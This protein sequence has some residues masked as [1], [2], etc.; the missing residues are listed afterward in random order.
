MGFDTSIED[1]RTEKHQLV[2]LKPRY[3]ATGWSNVSGSVYRVAVTRG[4]ISGVW[5]EYDSRVGFSPV[6]SLASLTANNEYFFDPATS[7]LYVFSQDA[8]LN[9][10]DPDDNDFPGLTVEFELH[11]SDQEFIGPRDPLDATS[12]KV[13]WIPALKESPLAQIGR[14]GF[15]LRLPADEHGPTFPAEPRRVAERNPLRLQL[16]QLQRG[17]IRAGE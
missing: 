4:Y 15:D 16:L 12:T 8:L 11:V 9:P 2:V 5:N 1:N 10:L 7:Y 13:E 3:R 14:A 17:I 6:A